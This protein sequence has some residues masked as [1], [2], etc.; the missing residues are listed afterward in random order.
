MATNRLPSAFSKNDLLQA[1]KAIHD[2]LEKR[3]E[4]KIDAVTG[5]SSQYADSVVKELKE[6]LKSWVK[7]LV[8]SVLSD[9]KVELSSFNKSVDS[10]L[11]KRIEDVTARYDKQISVMENVYDVYSKKVGSFEMDLGVK[12]GRT[13]EDKA[14]KFL[15]VELDRRVGIELEKKMLVVAEQH[16]KH[17]STITDSHTKQLSLIEEK[18]QQEVKFVQDVCQ[19]TLDQMTALVE[20]LSMPAPQVNVTVPEQ[21]TP[22]V[23]VSI[24]ESVIN[25]TV[26]E[27][28]AP[29]VVVQQ[30]QPRLVKKYLTYDQYNRPIEI[31]E[32][33]RV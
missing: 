4:S 32:E 21:P 24:P 22:Q 7:E 20:R 2:T 25:V 33:E 12:L 28:P 9:V 30:A 17:I 14:N 26:P 10:S 8:A 27:Q 16:N 1:S 5:S 13:M 15:D 29:Q 19:R 18:Y 23:N 6:E 11:N 31:I 3:I